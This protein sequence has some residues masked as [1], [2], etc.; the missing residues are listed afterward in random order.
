[1]THLL[2]SGETRAATFETCEIALAPSQRSLHTRQLLP[3]MGHLGSTP[4]DAGIPL[5][6][7][8]FRAREQPTSLT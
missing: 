5:L 3:G 8:H 1:M 2:R 4:I 6:R 7:R